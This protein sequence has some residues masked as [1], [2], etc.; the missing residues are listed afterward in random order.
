MISNTQHNECLWK[1]HC[2]SDS[3]NPNI[4]PYMLS[5][6]L[7]M[8]YLYARVLLPNLISCFPSSEITPFW[9]WY[10]CI[11]LHYTYVAIIYIAL[12]CIL[13]ILTLII[14][15][16]F[17]DS[18]L[19]FWD[20]SLLIK[21]LSMVPLCEGITI[22]PVDGYLCGLFLFVCFLLRQTMSQW[23]YI[24][25]KWELLEFTLRSKTA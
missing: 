16:L 21:L 18:D 10:L 11:C 1:P 2:Y 7:K 8:E 24:V 14:C 3:S 12:Y 17:F 15:K 19:Y 9:V 25:H 20:T 13:Q 23:T 6:F 4:L 22:C 5:I